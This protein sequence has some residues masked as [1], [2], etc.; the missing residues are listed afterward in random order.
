LNILL[1][2]AYAQYC[3]N[4][5]S[6][7][8]FTCW[9]CEQMEEKYAQFRYWSITLKMEL[10]LMVFLKSIRIGDFQLYKDSIKSMLSWFFALDHY[11]YARWL[12]IH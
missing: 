10:T 7:S 4:I 11:N 8:D 1:K 6:P 3:S 12:T 5:S 9:W 2:A